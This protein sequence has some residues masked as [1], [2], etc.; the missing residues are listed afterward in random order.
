[1]AAAPIVP[2]IVNRIIE[3][4]VFIDTGAELNMMII[5]ISDRAGLVIRT[6][7]KVKMSLYSE[8]ISCFLEMVE[9]VLISVNLIVYRVNIFVIRSTPQSFILE[10]S[11]L[12]FTRAQ[13][14]FN[15]NSM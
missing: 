7:V 14:L 5:N 10:I 15:D 6:R 9:N 1:M 8:Y 2:V 4:S 13:L 3:C 11:Y 12:H